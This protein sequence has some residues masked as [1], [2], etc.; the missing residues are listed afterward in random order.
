MAKQHELFDSEPAPWELDENDDNEVEEEKYESESDDYKDEEDDEND[1]TNALM[2]LSHIFETLR[3][4]DDWVP[5]AAPSTS[6]VLLV[7]RT[8]KKRRRL[9]PSREGF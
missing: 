8:R 4:R 3:S 1:D 6:N 2:A 9:N 5:S 7:N